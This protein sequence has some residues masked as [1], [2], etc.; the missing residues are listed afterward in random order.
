MKIE[1]NPV[2]DHNKIIF[3]VHIPKSGG[4]TIREGLL[5]Y[6]NSNE[7]LRFDIPS[8]THYQ[9]KN[10]FLQ[11]EINNSNKIKLFLKKIPLLNL[12]RNRIRYYK[13]SISLKKKDPIFRDFYSLTQDELQKLRFIS[14]TQERNVILPILGKNNP[15][16]NIISDKVNQLIISKNQSDINLKEHIKSEFDRIYKVY[17]KEKIY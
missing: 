4:S 12:I 15:K 11:S 8:F 7:C 6:F 17:F 13:N 9:N 3:N 2:I 14:S 16:D 10:T 5:Q 1:T